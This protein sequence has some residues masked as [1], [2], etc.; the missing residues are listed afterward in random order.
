[1]R[2]MCSGKAE[3]QGDVLFDLLHVSAVKASRVKFS[4]FFHKFLQASSSHK[5]PY[6]SDQADIK[7]YIAQS[8]SKD[9]GSGIANLSRR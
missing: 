7:V 2:T 6:S 3:V 1:M 9:A 5:N 4:G 8:L